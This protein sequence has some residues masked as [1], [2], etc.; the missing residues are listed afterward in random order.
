MCGIVAYIGKENC[1][2]LLISALKRLEYR[3]Y[4]SAGIAIKKGDNVYIR[5]SSGRIDKIFNNV[6]FDGNIG[7]AHTR[8][9]THGKPST[10]NSHPMY[11]CKK[12]FFVVHNGIVE[13]YTSIKKM[14]KNKGHKFESDTDSE[15]IAHLIE[16]FYRG[17]FVEA[18]RNAIAEIDGTYGIVALSKSHDFLVAARKGSPVV[19]GIGDDFNFVAS[20]VNAFVKH[21]KRVIYMDDHEIAVVKKSVVRISDINGI[22]K[23]KNVKVLRMK[24][25]EI[26]KCGYKHF[27][28]KEIMEQPDSLRNTMAGRLKGE[29]IKLSINIDFNKLKRIVIGACG[30]SW[31]AGIVGKYIIEKFCRIPVSVE[32]ASEFRYMDPII[33]KNDLFIAVSQSG[34][35]ADT[36]AA[37]K[38]A[39]KKGA[40]VM[41]IVNV[42]GS[43]IAR[44]AKQGIYLH[45]GPEIGVASTKAFTSQITSF[46]LLGMYIRKKMLGVFDVDIANQLLL[47]PQKIKKILDK[48]KVIL[49]IAKR[50]KDVNNFLYLGRGINY[51][52]ALEGALKMKEISYIHAEGLPAAEMKHGPIALIDNNMPV[53]FIATKNG[54]AYRKTLSNMEEVRARDGIIIAICNENDRT[55]LNLSNYII[56]VPKV[57][58]FLSPIVNVIPLQL[59]AYYIADLKG[60]DV[61][62]PRNLA[63]SVTVE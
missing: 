36:L 5:K 16:E 45:A 17:D 55:V 46:L 48:S 33:D 22:I 4:D 9:A 42:V 30:T 10:K 47:L 44:E 13:N 18:V 61:D 49:K 20:D 58:E 52:V 59:L 12:N 6:N 3:G 60:I 32:Y 57:N 31:H 21:T 26:E 38:E 62:K 29:D 40:M 11:D 51:P 28:L 34:E 23:K 56:E 50:F 37:L 2:N 15:V 63:K 27:M 1:L 41:G 35:T 14:L 8:W 7:I 39:K 53:I 19:I 54:E 43:T 24:I 25:E